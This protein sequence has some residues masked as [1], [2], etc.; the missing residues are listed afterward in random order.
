MVRDDL[1]DYVVEGLGDPSG[2]L[3]IAEAGF[4]KKGMKSVG[5]AKQHNPSAELLENCQVGIFLAYATPRGWA[6][7]DRALYL[8]EEWSEDEKRR[9][10][11]GV[12]EEVEY[13]TKGE[14]AWAMLERAFVAKVPAVWV[15]GGEAYGRD[16]G[17]RRRLRGQRNPYVLAVEH[18]KGMCMVVD[19]LPTQMWTEPSTP[20]AFVWQRMMVGIGREGPL[21]YSWARG[22]LPIRT[23]VGWAQWLLVRRW[24]IPPKKEHVYYRTVGPVIDTAGRTG[25]YGRHDLVGQ[26]GP[27]AGEGRGGAGP[28]RDQALGGL[29]PARHP[30]LTGTRLHTGHAAARE[31]AGIVHYPFSRVRPRCSGGR[32]SGSAAALHA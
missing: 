32:G 20:N 12:P 27:R 18:S 6:F 30:V 10:M 15:T 17:L 3:V 31:A 28:V 9:L 29:A 16:E 26:G 13:A 21:D 24:G 11:A 4:P 25:A 14:L 22:R 5:V 8:P 1:R 7:I 23:A 2:V 19:G